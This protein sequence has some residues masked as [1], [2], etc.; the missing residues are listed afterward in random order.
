[1]R[2]SLFI[3]VVVLCTSCFHTQITDQIL[4]D[5]ESYISESPDSA[6]TVLESIKRSDLKSQR[7]KAHHALLHAMALDKSFIDVTEDS[8]AC[9]AVNYF[10]KHGPKKYL[11][12]S[13]Y[14]KGLSYFYDKQYNK[15]IIELSKAERDA[16]KHD[17]LYL[18]FIKMLQANIYNRNYNEIRAVELLEQ[19]YSIYTDLQTEH[20]I[21][22][23]KSE[24]A[25]AYTNLKRYDDAQRLLNE[26]LESNQLNDHMFWQAM[27]DYAFLMGTRTNADYKTSIAYYDKTAEAKGGRYL[28]KQD[29]WVWAHALAQTGNIKKSQY[30]I[31]ML[32]P[33]DTSGTAY[34]WQY[35]IA[36]IQGRTA[37]ALSLFEKFSEKNNEEVVN[38]LRQSISN[39]QRD[40][41]QSQHEIVSY[42]VRIREFIIFFV[43]ILSIS[44]IT[45]ITAAAVGYKRKKEKE[46][47]Y[48]IK[49]AEEVKRQLDEFKSGTYS[50][51]QKKYISMHKA[52][53]ETLQ[54][55]FEKYLQS[56]D[57]IDV[58]QLIYK[59]FVS[60]IEELQKDIEN[61]SKF[62]K[63]LN[64]ELGGVMTHL[65]IEFPKLT[66]RY[67]RMFGYLALGF[68]NP[69]IS[70]F[71]CCSENAVRIVKNRL[72]TIIKNSDAEHK[73]EFLEI[74]G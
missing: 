66:T 30:L 45:L 32:S 23:A 40:Y 60:L 19:A 10:Q 63:Y 68:S 58:E 35:T 53:Y 39:V 50:D 38:T 46:Q 70:H 11:V 51:L 65:R 26:L 69:I 12:R 5:V 41:Y 34:Y 52:K 1:M 62:D 55:L 71:M 31:D 73:S 47:D 36:K 9:I 72:K 16:S 3:L 48:Y 25:V 64:T 14:Y 27:S 67:Y 22:V 21:N 15:S 24:L 59:K 7:Q 2:I 56:S 42:K 33:I 61:S 28:S 54:I 43:T 74:I 49:Y 44:S 13:L 8:L 57:R 29:Y 18:G 4:K 37:E 6:L 17:S 20:Y